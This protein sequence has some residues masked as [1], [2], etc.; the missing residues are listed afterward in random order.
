[1]QNDLAKLLNTYNGE[2]VYNIASFHGLTAQGPKKKSL[3]IEDLVKVLSDWRYVLQVLNGLSKLERA[4]V[5]AILRRAGKTSLRNIKEELSRLGLLDSDQSLGENL[6]RSHEK[7]RGKESRRIENILFRLLLSGFVFDADI[8]AG[9]HT[10]DEGKLN[11]HRAPLNVFIP[12]PIRQFLPQP[13]DLPLQPQAPLQITTIQESSARVFQR[14]LYLYWS[15]VRDHTPSITLKGEIEK[16]SLREV[17]A[18]LL[19]RA[20]LAKAETENDYPRLRFIRSVLSAI[21]LID[22]NEKRNLVAIAAQK[23]FS[24]SPAGRVRA[25]YENWR[26]SNAFNELLLLP[27]DVRPRVNKALFFPASPAVVSARQFV[28][29]QVEKLAVGGWLS[30]Q[31]LVEAVR[32]LDYEFLIPRAGRPYFYYGTVNVY[33]YPLNPLGLEFPGVTSDESGWDKVEAN[34]IKDILWGPLFWMGLVD[35]GWEGPQKGSPSAYRLTP[36]GSWILGQGPQ[37]HIPAEGGQVIVQ[38]NLHII[39]LDPIREETLIDLDHFAERLAAERAVEYQL[40]R[41]SVYHG[42]QTGWEVPRIKKYLVDQTGV[43]LPANVAR[44]LDEW[45]MQYERI[46]IRPR[47]AI[48]HGS[49]AVIDRLAENS[50]TASAIAARP[51]AEL[52]VLKNKK[53]IPQVVAALLA[54]DILPVVSSRALVEP[55]S[56]AVS[57]TGEISF[58][59]RTPSLYLHGHLAAFAEREESG[60]RITPASVARAAVTGLTAPE[61]I[62]RLQAVHSG[63]VPELLMRRIRAWSRHY[64][65]A[66]L[67]QVILFQVRDA[68]TLAELMDDPEVGPLLAPFTPPDT[69]A[70]ARVR[71]ADLAKLRSLLAERG[72]DLIKHPE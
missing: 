68:D 15:F 12:S 32:E 37:P 63:S 19:V 4:F 7:P 55:G 34:F 38:P 36:L 49:V 40:T 11:I 9:P 42:Q 20:D 47:L 71:P 70:L 18:T 23:F 58:T 21:G 67:E 33:A 3:M 28:I 17:N 31:T 13:A 51:L 52:A 39:A 29:R 30:F 64:G 24:T 26:D 22:I 27:E 56:V 62:S 50:Q 10:Y 45:Q 57:D 61:I 65:S 48:A 46:L 35:L 1:M 69:R 6:P 54:A 14:D 44:T 43:D 66:T 16:R 8:L 41:Q 5:D 60:Y 25:V 72:I 2:S 59:C 53:V